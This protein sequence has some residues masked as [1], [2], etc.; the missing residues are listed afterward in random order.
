MVENPYDD[1]VS[2]FA[3]TFMRAVIAWNNAETTARDILVSFGGNSIGLRI[4]AEHLGARSMKDALLTLCD[5]LAPL[6][7]ERSTEIAP[8]IAHFIEGMDTLRAYRNFYVHSLAYTGRSMSDRDTYIGF[9][10]ASEARGRL[11]WVNEKLTTDDL[12][13]FMVHTLTL[14]R[15]G[16]QL[17]RCIPFKVNALAGEPP[18]EPAPLPEKPTWPKKLT[19]LR[20]YL[21]KPP[22]QP[23]ASQA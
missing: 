14:Q 18:F 4:A 2:R 8:H 9:L 19:K 17:A 3:V 7:F 20:S 11:A 21:P 10:Q 13:K 5:T 1:D 6:D 22:P 16:E 23:E 15:Y 12:E